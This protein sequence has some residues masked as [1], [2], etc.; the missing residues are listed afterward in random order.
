[1]EFQYDV[2]IIIP[3]Y[4]EEG[5][6]KKIIIDTFSTFDQI[7]KNAEI[8]VI[9]DG[10]TDGTRRIVENLIASTD[11]LKIKNI[12]RNRGKSLALMDGFAIAKGRYVGF[13]DA[14]YQFMPHDFIKFVEILDNSEADIV[15]GYRKMRKDSFFKRF[16][17]KIFNFLNK[18]SFGTTFKDWNSGI[19]L[20]KT[21]VADN[22]LLRKNYHRYILGLSHS[23]YFR[24]KEI[25]ITHQEREFGE[26][27]YGPSRL[28]IGSFDLLSLKIKTMIQ[29]NPFLI[30]GIFGI[31]A[32]LSGFVELIYTL[33]GRF[34][35]RNL[36]DISQE[37]LL[38]V[39]LILFGTQLF[40]FGYLAE[41]VSDIELR[42][43][44]ILRKI[45]D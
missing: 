44:K 22:L 25:P 23:S 5:T 27:K 14:D 16:P 26:S 7:K 12:S 45:D 4:N 1:M 34:I 39:L 30:F 19:K 28:I 42:Q 15:N 36:K 24:V 20:M 9:N 17:S 29:N 10:S 6:I 41:K 38:G 21:E 43:E 35:Q 13:I 40:A 31:V 33:Y 11:N 32:F 8:I 3:T 37:L 18:V 2:S